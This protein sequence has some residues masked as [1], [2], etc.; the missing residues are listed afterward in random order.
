MNVGKQQLFFLWLC[1]V[2]VNRS[3]TYRLFFTFL[4]GSSTAT[5]MFQIE[6]ILPL[7]SDRTMVRQFLHEMI[8]VEL[9]AN[10]APRKHPTLVL[11]LSHACVSIRESRS[12]SSLKR[13]IY[14]NVRLKR[15]SVKE[16]RK[17]RE[18]PGQN[19]SKIRILFLLAIA[20]SLARSLTN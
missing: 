19:W 3:E 11:C 1:H 6:I 4:F 7:S 14:M 20:H 13:N 8:S 15:H 16:N 2:V 5:C 10:N 12:T 17:H 18:T 9:R